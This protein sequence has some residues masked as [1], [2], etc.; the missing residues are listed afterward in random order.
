MGMMRALPANGDFKQALEFAMKALPL[1]PNE[2]NKS[3]VQ[4]M[5]EKLK[6]SNDMN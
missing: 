6:V 1:A 5:I 4:A 2:P 3:A